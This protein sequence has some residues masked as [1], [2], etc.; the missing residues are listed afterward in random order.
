MCNVS[1]EKVVCAIYIYIYIYILIQSF[2]LYKQK[3]LEYIKDDRDNEHET[4]HYNQLEP[5]QAKQKDNPPPK[6]GKLH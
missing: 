2:D 4:T 6:P 5:A 3:K 1:I